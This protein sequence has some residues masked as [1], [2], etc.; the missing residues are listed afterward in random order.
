VFDR[1]WVKASMPDAELRRQRRAFWHGIR[2]VAAVVVVFAAIAVYAVVQSARL[3]AAHAELSEA[4]V[5][6]VAAN[7]ESL[8]DR[9]T[10]LMNGG[11]PDG[12]LD[13]LAA[14]RLVAGGSDEAWS[15]DMLWAG[16]VQ[17]HKGISHLVGHDGAIEGWDFSAD[18]TLFATGSSDATARVWH[19]ATG[20]AVTPPLVHDSRVSAVRLSADGRVLASVYEEG[21]RIRF[22]DVP[23]GTSRGAVLELPEPV[24]SLF[25][26]SE[27]ATRCVTAAPSGDLVHVRVWETATGRQVHDFL[28]ENKGQLLPVGLEDGGTR[29]IT[30]PTSSTVAVYSVDTGVEERRI[31]LP[32][33]HTFYHRAQKDGTRAVG[34][35]NGSVTIFDSD[36]RVRHGFIAHVSGAVAQVKLSEDGSTLATMGPILVDSQL[37]LWS[38]RT[39]EPLA[40]TAQIGQTTEVSLS[41]S[42]KYLHVPDGM[43][44]SV[45]DTRSGHYVLPPTSIPEAHDVGFFSP[46]EEGL[47]AIPSFHRQD[48]MVRFWRMDSSKHVRDL[49]VYDSLHGRNGTRVAFSPDGRW[50]TT[51]SYNGTEVQLWH[52]EDESPY[53]DPFEQN[54]LVRWIEFSPDSSLVAVAS[55]DPHPT[56]P[57]MGMPHV[58]LWDVES[59]QP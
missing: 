21:R 44:T 35:A 50:F 30:G 26:I 8:A 11:N 25:A 10:L 18:G 17:N 34:M 40:V 41:P 14:R 29:L 58:R 5:D 16:H 59:R 31:T 3:R 47:L 48:G 15:L 56:I 37:K 39:G 54:A 27:D 19:T 12:L 33:V 53:G 6:S 22:W 42:G 9:G 51:A 55:S 24:S 2:R 7:A 20:E 1:A 38:A 57:L 32:S 36:W 28:A 43:K 46:S 49:E 13:I 4:L 23:R 52:A 45:I